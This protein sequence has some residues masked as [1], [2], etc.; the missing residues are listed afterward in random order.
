MFNIFKSKNKFLD[1]LLRLQK[2]AKNTTVRP[3]LINV[4]QTNT[5]GLEVGLEQLRGW[6]QNGSVVGV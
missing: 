3:V 2:L 1:C 5:V 4:K 6:S